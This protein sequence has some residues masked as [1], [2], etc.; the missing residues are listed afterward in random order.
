MREAIIRTRHN[1]SFMEADGTKVVRASDIDGPKK[2][3]TLYK[4]ISHEALKGLLKDGSIKLTYQDDANDPFECKPRPSVFKDERLKNIGIVSFT[5][6]PNN[7]PMWG[8]YADKFRGA[9][10]KFVFDYF[11]VDADIVPTSKGEVLALE[12]REYEK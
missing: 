1:F 2:H 6:T 12:S 10:L 4:Y 9:C 5:T 11:Y 3:I 8:N 7:H